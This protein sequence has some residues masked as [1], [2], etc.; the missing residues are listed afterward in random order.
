M[1]QCLEVLQ[2]L[3]FHVLEV[4]REDQIKI[5]MAIVMVMVILMAKSLLLGV[6]IGNVEWCSMECKIR[7]VVVEEVVI[8]NA[9]RDLCVQ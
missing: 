3:H 5:A 8:G 7:R 2:D 9:V 4:S 1:V 6:V